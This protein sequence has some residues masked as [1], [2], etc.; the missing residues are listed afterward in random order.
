MDPIARLELSVDTLGNLLEEALEAVDTDEKA[1][2]ESW[3]KEVEAGDLVL[4]LGERIRKAL[5]QV[6]KCSSSYFD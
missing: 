2:R 5:A 1:R 4:D 3:P 6:K